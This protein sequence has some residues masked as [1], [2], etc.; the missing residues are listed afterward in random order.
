MEKEPSLYRCSICSLSLQVYPN[1]KIIRC[2]A[3]LGKNG[4]L[5]Q[6]PTLADK[7]T[8][9]KLMTEK[10]SIGCGNPLKLIKDKLVK[11]S[12]KTMS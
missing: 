8:I 9:K 10:L 2:G 3:T 7:K 5:Y 12:W 1:Q 11:T 6:L 4:I